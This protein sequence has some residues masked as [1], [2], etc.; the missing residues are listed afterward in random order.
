MTFQESIYILGLNV[1]FTETD[2]KR[3]YRIKAK[4][5]HPDIHGVQTEGLMKKVNAAHDF[6]LEVLKGERPRE[7]N[8]G[9]KNYTGK[10]SN[11]T[12]RG[13]NGS[14]T[15][16]NE[17]PDAAF[18]LHLLRVLEKMEQ[19]T[20]RTRT[21]ET[22]VLKD[23]IDSFYNK[24]KVI[25]DKFRDNAGNCKTKAQLDVEVRKYMDAIKGLY[26]ELEFAFLDKYPYLRNLSYKLEYNVKLDT[27]LN[28]LNNLERDSYYDLFNKILDA[29]RLKYGSDKLYR[30]IIDPIEKLIRDYADIVMKGVSLNLNDDSPLFTKINQLF[31]EQKEKEERK[32]KLRVAAILVESTCSLKIRHFYDELAQ[33]VDSPDFE[34]LYQQFMEHGHLCT[35]EKNFRTY[36]LDKMNIASSIAND[37]NDPEKLSDILM[38]FKRILNVFE[39]NRLG[40]VSFD[41]LTDLLSVTFNNLPQDRKLIDRTIGSKDILNYNNILLSKGGLFDLAYLYMEDGQYYVQTE[42]LGFL[43]RRKVNDLRELDDK[44]V[45]LGK[46]L[47]TANFVGKEA[48]TK[49]NSRIYVLYD[50]GEL[51]M[52]MDNDDQLRVCRATDI[53]RIISKSQTNYV[54]DEYKDHSLVIREFMGRVNSSVFR[55]ES[56]FTR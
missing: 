15:N 55:K 38:T 46:F 44:Y 37:N 20:V 35:N 26:T 41:S 24:I 47:A 22:H 43:G 48:I 9:P 13:N 29:V 28:N 21:Y 53:K 39:L 14:Q 18:Y 34:E 4:E 8:N 7:I 49:I 11:R 31:V 52:Y 23:A 56:K 45:S 33:N 50:N 1:D 36:L 27:F 12:N 6:L 25:Y 30:N 51:C 42:L 16:N 19:F 32:N 54:Y 10:T 40:F 2:L 3:A 5:Y 17:G